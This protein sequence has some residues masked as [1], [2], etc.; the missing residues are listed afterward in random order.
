MLCFRQA[1]GTQKIGSPGASE[2][3]LSRNK[4]D[5]GHMRHWLLLAASMALTWASALT[6]EIGITAV[7]HW[8]PQL[9][10]ELCCSLGSLRI[11]ARSLCKPQH[12]SRM[13]Q[14][15]QMTL[16]AHGFDSHSLRIWRFCKLALTKR[17]STRERACPPP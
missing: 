3:R 13:P 11:Q 1:A 12:M 8:H 16:P 10:L 15:L 17:M 2:D 4:P 9:P 5:A 7:R 6:K 14:D